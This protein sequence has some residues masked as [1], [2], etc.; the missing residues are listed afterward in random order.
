MRILY[1]V[2]GTGNGHLTRAREMAKAFAELTHVEVQFLI[3]G[4]ARQALF[5]V[6]PLGAFQWREG[7][8]FAT[9]NGKVS[10]VDTIS[11]NPWWRFWQDVHELDLSPYDLVVTDF[12][13]VT[14]WAA[15]RQ[16]VPCIGLG[17]QYAFTKAHPDLPSTPLQRAMI[18]QF[19][20]CQLA[21]GTHW[22]PL[23]T[24]TLPPIIEPVS[25][26]ST[27]QQEL[28]LI[29]LPFE[30]VESVI[31]L[32]AELKL[33]APTYRFSVFHPQAVALKTAN[34]SFHQ[35]CRASFQKAFSESAG[36]ISNAGF[37]T[38]SEALA[39]GKKLLVKPLKGQFEQYANAQCLARTKLAQVVEKLDPVFLA[40][41]LEQGP[42][43]ALSWTRVAPELATWLAQHQRKDI[44]LL[45]QDLWRSSQDYR[46]QA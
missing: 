13:P 43:P 8:S 34:A 27:V 22:E 25:S 5:G 38:S 36:V 30:P 23:N 37:G 16:G 41:W 9:R 45:S 17:R 18:K 32:V 46:Q 35:P 10:M 12:E 4:R 20:P 6:E 44:A 31:E 7:L 2:Q 29:Y 42:S 21:I 19:A 33:L 26:L 14:A 1:G 24:K 15:K 39:A 40:C 28:Y 3:S 11:H